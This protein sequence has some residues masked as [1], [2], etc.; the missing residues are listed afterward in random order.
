MICEDIPGKLLVKYMLPSK[1][2][3]AIYYS[4]DRHFNSSLTKPSYKLKVIWIFFV[5]QIPYTRVNEQISHTTY[6]QNTCTML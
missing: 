2:T 3:D 1:I 6:I 5:I 4:H